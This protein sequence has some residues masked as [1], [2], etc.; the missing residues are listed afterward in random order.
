[1]KMKQF[2]KIY[3]A[4]FPKVACFLST[5]FRNSFSIL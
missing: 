3:E 2:L 4:V 1:M 5:N